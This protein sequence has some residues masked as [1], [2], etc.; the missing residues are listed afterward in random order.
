MCIIYCIDVLQLHNKIMTIIVL[1]HKGCIQSK[2]SSILCSVAVPCVLSKQHITIYIYR[3]LFKFLI[4]CVFCS[5][6]EY[7]DQHMDRVIEQQYYTRSSVI[8]L[9][10]MSM[11]CIEYYVAFTHIKIL[12]ER[13]CST[14]KINIIL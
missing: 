7:E 14:T 5:H 12:L 10:R 1:C 3:Q 8:M 9:T 13:R 6:L 2:S 4:D 11:A